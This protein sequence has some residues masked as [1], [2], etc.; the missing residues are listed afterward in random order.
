M[1]EG[2]Y[3]VSYDVPACYSS[4]K[5]FSTLFGIKVSGNS[6]N[7]NDFTEKIKR[8]HAHNLSELYFYFP[9]GAS[10]GA[11]QTFFNTNAR[12]MENI[13]SG[14]FK[15]DGYYYYL[16]ETRRAFIILNRI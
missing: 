16:E 13:A 3:Q 1:I 7:Q 2:R 9:E 15:M 6:F 14:Y 8:I 11:A 12:T 10:R 4:D 5:S